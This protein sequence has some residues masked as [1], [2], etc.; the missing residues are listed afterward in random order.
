MTEGRLAYSDAL[1]QTQSRVETKV[2]LNH[3]SYSHYISDVLDIN[4]LSAEEERYY[5]NQCRQ[6]DRKARD[7]MIEANL[8]LV[9][10]ISR[11]YLKRHNHH[12]SLLDLIEEGNIGLIKAIDKFDPALGYRFS[13]YAVWWIKESI[14]SGLM[15][16]GRTVR[17]PVH[18][19]KEINRL[20]VSNH[21][22]RNL[23][24]REMSMTEL[25]KQIDL[26]IGKVSDLVRLSGFIETS[27][28]VDLAQPTLGL[29]QYES[30]SIRDPQEEF[31]HE[32]FT[33]A[34]EKVIKTLPEK[35][36]AVLVARYGL[37]NQPVQT[38]TELAKCMDLSTERVRQLHCE[39]I[40]R[41]QKRLKFDE[42]I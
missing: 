29:D 35:I 40:K 17:L 11:T 32:Q 8:R 16:H 4:L 18:I 36:Q 23:V 42:W 33:L 15:N 10:K 41:V 1:N 3:D 13:T 20:A 39:A 38:L 26:P 12:F 24:S 6:G 25:A 22:A 28:T 7:I 9:V 27:T 34:L 5:T 21:K 14:E 37:F 19:H 30:E 2:S 31:Q